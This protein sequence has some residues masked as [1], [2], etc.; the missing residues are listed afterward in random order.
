MTEVVLNAML[1]ICMNHNDFLLETF[2]EDDLLLKT[3]INTERSAAFPHL[4]KTS[5]QVIYS[6]H[7]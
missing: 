1:D 4:T 7:K 6:V 3:V 2:I 5:D